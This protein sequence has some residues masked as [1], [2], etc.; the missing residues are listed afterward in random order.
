MRPFYSCLLL[1][2]AVACSGMNVE[3]F[4]NTEPRLVIEEYFKGSTR[5]WGVVHDRFGNLTRQFTVDLQGEWDGKQLVL[6]EDFR[7]SDGKTEQRTWYIDKV[8][9]HTYEGRAADV[10]GVARGRQFGQALNWNYV[11]NLPIGDSTWK[12]RF[13]DWMY[14]QPDNVLINRASMSK[15][16][17]NVGEVLISFRKY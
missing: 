2:L 15:V 16:G 8:D 7:Y 12:I 1:L 5:G 6:H 11:L 9:D 17:L 4:D 14:L 13:D 3:Q 10:V